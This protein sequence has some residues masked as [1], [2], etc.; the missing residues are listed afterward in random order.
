MEVEILSEHDMII[1]VKEVSKTYK[2]LTA[3]IETSLTFQEN[4]SVAIMGTSGSGK[5]TLLHIVA[6]VIESDTGSVSYKAKQEFIDITKLSSSKRAEL[7]LQEFGFVFQQG[8]LLP[9]LTALENVIMPLLLTGVERVEAETKAIDILSELDMLKTKDKRIG[10]LSG[11]QGQRI[12]IAR[13][14]IT[15]PCV[16]FADEPTGSLD[17]KTAMQV[18][19][20]LL[21]TVKKRGKTLIMVTHNEHIAKQCDRLITIK[22]G[23]IV[24]DSAELSGT[25]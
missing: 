17:N 16:V 13:A 9:E 19:K 23:K 1:V 8:L 5:S 2:D 10:Q 3:L 14:L 18:T 21:D 12:A 6:G 4:Q 11:G 25:Q 20:I 22:S 7:R 15:D 24:V